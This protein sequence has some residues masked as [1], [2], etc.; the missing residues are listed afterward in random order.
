[1]RPWRGGLL[2]GTAIASTELSPR[3]RVIGAEPEG[4]DD[5][6]RSLAA[7]KIHPVGQIRKPS[8]TGS[9]LLLRP[10][11]SDHS[12][13]CGADSHG[14]RS[15][16]HRGHEIRMGARENHHR[17]FS[18]CAGGRPMERKLDLSGLRIGVHSFQVEMWIW[19]DCRGRTANRILDERSHSPIVWRFL[20]QPRDSTQCM[21]GA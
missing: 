16:H 12:E 19:T 21:E 6:F 11:F 15:Q 10:D 4:A 5:A 20:L 3:I 8:R 9:G 7:G 1:L 14:E 13:A 17:T 2:S 18:R